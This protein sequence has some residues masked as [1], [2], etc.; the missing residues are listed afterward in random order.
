MKHALQSHTQDFTTN[1]KVNSSGKM[2]F[3]YR[4]E[5]AL[6]FAHNRRSLGHSVWTLI[7]SLCENGPVASLLSHTF[8]IAA[9]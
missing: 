6:T 7:T 2:G 5:F 3:S 4:Q 9:L 1:G 8:T